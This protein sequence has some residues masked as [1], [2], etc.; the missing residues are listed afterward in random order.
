MTE[1]GEKEAETEAGKETEMREKLTNLGNR[2]IEIDAEAEVARGTEVE[3]EAEVMIMI[4]NMGVTGS[5]IVIE[6]GNVTV[7]EVVETLI[8]QDRVYK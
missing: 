6:K 8:H 5:A 1:I 3:R 2:R 7:T 4:E